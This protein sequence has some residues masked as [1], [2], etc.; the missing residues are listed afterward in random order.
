MSVKEK[1]EEE[2]YRVPEYPNQEKG[3]FFD[4]EKFSKFSKD[5]FTVPLYALFCAIYLNIIY[6]SSISK[7]LQMST[8]FISFFIRIL[9]LEIILNVVFKPK[10]KE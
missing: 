9:I 8:L 4:E 7:S 3:F 1:E 2:E 6:I 5:I 10:K